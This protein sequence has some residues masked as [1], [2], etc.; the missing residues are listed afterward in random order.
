MNYC[1]VESVGSGSC[2]IK[3]LRKNQVC[4][5]RVHKTACADKMV[6]SSPVYSD[7]FS[8]IIAAFTS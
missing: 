3:L 7:L 6:L 2:H 8:E 1:R 5:P 4:L